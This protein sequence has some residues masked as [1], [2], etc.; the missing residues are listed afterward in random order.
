M[1]KKTLQQRIEESFDSWDSEFEKKE[2]K[3]W[4]SIDALA[5]DEHKKISQKSIEHN[6][7]ETRHM[8]DKLLKLLEKD[9]VISPNGTKVSP[10]NED[11]LIGLSMKIYNKTMTS[12]RLARH[13]IGLSHPEAAEMIR[14]SYK[15][16]SEKTPFNLLR[17]KVDAHFILAEL[18][19]ALDVRTNLSLADKSVRAEYMKVAAEGEIAY[20]TLGNSKEDLI[21]KMRMAY[22]IGASYKRIYDMFL[23]PLAEQLNKSC[24]DPEQS[25]RL[26]YGLQPS[27]K[28]K[29][30]HKYIREAREW[31]HKL[32]EAKAQLDGK[33]F[34][35]ATDYEFRRYLTDIQDLEIECA[36]Q[37]PLMKGT[38]INC[39]KSIGSKC[40]YQEHR[41]CSYMKGN[42]KR[43]E[44]IILRYA[45]TKDDDFFN[46]VFSSLTDNQP[47]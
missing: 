38:L 28:A 47:T 6:F 15:D 24:T 46:R 2:N 43:C 31:Y 25:A 30:L 7:E 1:T 45:S 5:V 42:K 33:A 20:N 4:S 36:F 9:H 41:Q 14:D 35:F 23:R 12:L 39:S 29:S 32:F 13:L 27:L 34:L 16:V 37:V 26:R 19:A 40:P 21:M 17:R 8:F 18:Y 44:E 3:F 10:E 11:Y 22:K